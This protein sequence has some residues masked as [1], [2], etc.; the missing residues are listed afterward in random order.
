[1]PLVAYFFFYVDSIKVLFLKTC[2][3]YPDSKYGQLMIL[4][5]AIF[6]YGQFMKF[7]QP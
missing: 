4:M 2:K 3:P 5:Y 6:F 1:M 7:L